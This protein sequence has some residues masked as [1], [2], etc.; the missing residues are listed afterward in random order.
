MLRDRLVY[1]VLQNLILFI[2]YMST[3]LQN[4]KYQT[5]IN[6]CNI[7]FETCEFCAT[8]CLREEDVKMMAKCIQLCHD[9]ATICVTASQVMSRDSDY[10]KQICNLCAN[11]YDACAAE[12][13][14]HQ[15]HME[16]CRL[17]AQACRKCVEEC[18][19]MA[20]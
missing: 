2:I 1:L 4:Q 5:C 9:C 8:L 19:I 13:E 18:R 12:C 7:C 6:A 3:N 10:V 17:C 14:K 20:R 16:H 15:Q 11:I